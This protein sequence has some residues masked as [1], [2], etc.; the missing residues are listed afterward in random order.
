[1]AAAVASIVVSGCG[2][3]IDGG[4]RVSPSSSPTMA[5]SATASSTAANDVLA[6]RNAAG[7][8]AC[9]SSDAAANKRSHGIEALTLACL[10][11]D[12]RVN[13]AGLATGRPRVVN[14][15]ASWC[16]PCRD[17]LPAIA[18]FAK[19]ASGR[20][21]FLGLDVGD[22]PRSA[23]QMARRAHVGYPQVTGTAAEVAELGVT[24][25][26]QTF[27]IRADGTIAYR[28]VGGVDETTLADLVLKHLGVRV[29]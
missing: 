7:I 3:K 10:G 9:P 16:P 11:G 2:Q 17:E 19:R 15:W 26:P 20:V 28:Q 29:R 13:L 12:S 1:M 5:S 25:L 18:S 8:P 24:A 23:I 27:L 6:L 4:P 14:I 21:D 22:D